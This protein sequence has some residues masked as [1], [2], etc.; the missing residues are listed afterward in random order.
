[1]ERQIE[2]LRG[3]LAAYEDTQLQMWR[4][5]LEEQQLRQERAQQS[6]TFARGHWL[7][8]TKKEEWFLTGYR[9]GRSEISQKPEK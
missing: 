8:I 4:E 3:S 2:Q 5:S 7:S 6:E 1:M 9:Q